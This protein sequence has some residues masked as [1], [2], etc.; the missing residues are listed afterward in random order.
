MHLNSSSFEDYGKI[1]QR[2]TG[3]GDNVSPALE[4]SEIPSGCKSLTLICEDIDAPKKSPQ[5]PAFTHWVVYNISPSIT[6]LHEGLEKKE[7]I[8]DPLRIDQ[9]LNSFGSIGYDGPKPPSED[10]AHRYIFTLFALDIEK[11]GPARAELKMIHETMKNHILKTAQI[12]GRYER[13]KLTQ[14]KSGEHHTSP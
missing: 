13:Q 5:D 11:L 8:H 7:E 6:A 14:A 4:W 10:M 9:G 12:T 1:P 2:F 3:D